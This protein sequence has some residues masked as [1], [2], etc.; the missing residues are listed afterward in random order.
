MSEKRTISR[1]EEVRER[2]TRSQTRR[3]REA[4]ERAYRPLPPVISRT[5]PGDVRPKPVKKT[6]AR[7]YNSTVGLSGRRLELPSL[8]G[9]S[10]GPRLI[11]LSLAAMLIAGLYFAW[12]SPFFRVSEAQVTGLS[13]L[14]AEEITSRLD[15]SGQII[16]LLQPGEIVSRLRQD[17]PE[18]ASAQVLVSLPNVVQI[19]ATE[20][21]PVLLWQQGNGY[22]WIDADGVAFRP[23]GDSAGLIPVASLGAPPAGDPVLQDP[24]IPPAYIAPDVVKAALALAPAVPA[25]STLTYDPRY[26]FGWTDSRGWQVYFG[27]KSKDMALKLRVY[28]SLVDSLVAQGITPAFISVIYADAPYY[29]MAE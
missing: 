1:A 11:S 4:G 28:Q 2:R 22:T 7:R 23:R 17:F 15:L 19:Q 29:R 27:D 5:L 25:G 20:R 16:F 14:G 18:L 6:G 26:G 21:Q 8:P 3:Q 9:L 10:A 24:L 13:R 12:T